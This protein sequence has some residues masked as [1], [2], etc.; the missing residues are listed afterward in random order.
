MRRVAWYLT[1]GLA[2]VLAAHAE[3]SEVSD[4]LLDGDLLSADTAPAPHASDDLLGGDLLS[5]EP[6]VG[7]D[8]D[9]LGGDLLS[10]EPTT[11]ADDGLLGGDLLADLVSFCLSAH[12]HHQS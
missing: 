5:P 8:N 4:A 7:A 9:L 12:V 10:P 1:A 11:D 2:L 3:E 6:T